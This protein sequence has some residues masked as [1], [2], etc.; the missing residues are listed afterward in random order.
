MSDSEFRVAK[1]LVELPELRGID[2][3]HTTSAATA[4][5]TGRTTSA[6]SPTV[7]ACTATATATATAAAAAA[8]HTEERS[9]DLLRWSQRV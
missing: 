7:E 8:A 4:L 3:R 6:Q 9:G 1:D 2:A 5:M